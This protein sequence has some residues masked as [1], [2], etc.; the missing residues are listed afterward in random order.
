MNDAHRRIGRIDSLSARTARPH[1][2]DVEILRI[3]LHIHLLGL[4][5]H[6]NRDRRSMNATVGFGDRNA[7]YAV[8][9]ALVFELLVD[10]LACHKDDYFLQTAA[11]RRA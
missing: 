9:A 2:A 3:D 10:L 4:R 11:I 8:H 1:H 6:G 5:Q 7:L